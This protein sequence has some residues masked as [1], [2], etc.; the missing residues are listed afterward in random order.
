MVAS[1][2]SFTH[3]L[4]QPSVSPFGTIQGVK[5]PSPDKLTKTN[6]QDDPESTVSAMMMETLDSRITK[7]ETGFN[8][9]NS[10]L[11]QL[12]FRT[13]QA[14]GPAPPNATVVSAAGSTKDPVAEA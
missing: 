14:N 8:S 9:I 13:K 4:D 5:T 7:L 12:V 1:S 6:W 2:Q 3:Q 11:E 10:L